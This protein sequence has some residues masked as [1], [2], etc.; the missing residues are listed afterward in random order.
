MD[1]GESLLIQSEFLGQEF[2]YSVLLPTVVVEVCLCSME[3]LMPTAAVDACLRS[4]EVSMPIARRQGQQLMLTAAVNACQSL[5]EESMPIE[6][7]Q[8][9]RLMSRLRAP[10]MSCSVAALARLTQA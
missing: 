5:V 1:Y 6:R 7:R 10:E 3:D 4:V 9:Q 2:W 8:D